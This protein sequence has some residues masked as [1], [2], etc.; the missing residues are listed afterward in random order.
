MR[1]HEFADEELARR[2]CAHDEHAFEA[3]YDRFA[4]S[5]YAV[6]LRVLG[7][8]GPAQDVAQEVFLRFWRMP[9][10]F[11]P[12]RG[13]FG[14][15]LL[16]VTRNRAVDEVRSRGRR[17]LRELGSPAMPDDPPD[18]TADDPARTAEIESDRAAVRRALAALP[19][20]QRETLEL[21]YFG[22]LTQQEIAAELGQP[23]GTV[24]TR[25]RLALQKL[26]ATLSGEVWTG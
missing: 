13:R 9:Q 26:R 17:R 8:P 5:V 18:E 2:V 7:E 16:S 20:E 3:L 25:T 4:D 12:E 1:A 19:T 11:D 21:A 22:G 23:L 14:T 6:A 10:G 15:W 24:K